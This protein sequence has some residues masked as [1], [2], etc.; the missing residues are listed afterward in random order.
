M[1]YQDIFDETYSLE[2]EH[3][4]SSNPSHKLTV[5]T[6]LKLAQTAVH[7]LSSSAPAIPARP[8]PTFIN[9]SNSTTPVLSSSQQTGSLSTGGFQSLGSIISYATATS[10]T[11][12]PTTSPSAGK[13]QSLGSSITHVVVT[14]ATGPVVSL[15]PNA[16]IMVALPPPV[17]QNE[18]SQGPTQQLSS[19]F[20]TP[21]EKAK[22][23][24]QAK[25]MQALISVTIFCDRDTSGRFD[26]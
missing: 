24:K 6:A 13:F 14:P 4:L 21:E 18:P 15:T 8:D 23:F 11:T 25:A 26:D 16:G 7:E 3:L 5:S 1:S 12:Q 22:K 9:H 19:F 17:G 10:P 20:S 2:L